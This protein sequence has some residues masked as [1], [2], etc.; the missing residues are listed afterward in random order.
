MLIDYKLNW[1]SPEIGCLV[2]KDRP[3]MQQSD[4]SL[5]CF[6]VYE[7]NYCANRIH[8]RGRY[9]LTSSPRSTIHRLKF[10]VNAALAVDENTSW[11]QHK[12]C[13]AV[14]WAALLIK[15]GLQICTTFCCERAFIVLHIKILNNRVTSPDFCIKKDQNTQWIHYERNGKLTLFKKP[16]SHSLSCH[17][18]L[19]Y[20]SMQS[21]KSAVYRFY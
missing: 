5:L 10:S 13:I 8:L 3:S 9:L 19:T 16:K 15:T 11:R 17:R 4:K 14:C 7:W 18:S 21:T 2:A 6:S 20:F 1:N 12:L